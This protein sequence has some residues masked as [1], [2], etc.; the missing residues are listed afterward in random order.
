MGTLPTIIM[1]Q[2]DGGQLYL[3]K[4]SMNTEILTSKCSGINVNIPDA[5]ATEEEEG[6]YKEIPLPEQIR[7]WIVDGK[8]MSEIVEHSG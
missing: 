4:N 8:V 3:G 6:D 5:A 2:V 1:D 7:T